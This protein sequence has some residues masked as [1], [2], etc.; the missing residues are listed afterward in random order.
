VSRSLPRPGVS[1]LSSQ[2]DD[3]DPLWN[4][5]VDVLDRR[6]HS[7]PGFVLRF[8]WTA[9][10]YRTVVL[11]G[12]LG[13]R[14]LYQDL[15]V[16]VLARRVT[17]RQVNV[18][19]TDCTWSPGSAALSGG[20]PLLQRLLTAAHRLLVRA[21]DGPRTTFCVLTEAERQRFP[22]LWGVAPE[23][24]VATPFSHTMWDDADVVPPRGDYVFAGGNSMRDYDLLM[25]ACRGL[26]AEVRVATHLHV[27]DVP[28]NVTVAPLGHGE[29]VEAL[30]GAG[31]VVVP[32]ED[33]GH[34]SAGQQTYLNAMLLGK[35]VVVTDS[36]GVREVVTDGVDGYVA[37]PSPAG[38]RTA[39]ERALRP[40]DPEETARIGHAARE[41]VLRDY[42]PGH[43]LA[44]LVAV[45][46]RA[47][48]RSGSD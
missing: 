4:A 16:A 14:D 6:R 9:R 8:A 48:R 40:A 20:R 15:V 39:L 10:R 7:W 13:R 2:W 30:K 3:S 11:L 31:V 41:T 17:H 19:L 28:P 27:R 23:R 45:A 44:R 21:V 42:T 1:V 34:R 24:V 43:Y 38:L 18:V 37:P 22:G 46:R 36:L 33:D 26:D 32:L 25:D 35:P 12:S 5:E 47:E 29:Y